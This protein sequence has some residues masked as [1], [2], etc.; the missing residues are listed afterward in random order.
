[1]NNLL[2]LLEAKQEVDMLIENHINNLTVNEFNIL[3]ENLAKFGMTG[4]KL[5]GTYAKS[6]N[7]NVSKKVLQTGTKATRFVI[8]AIDDAIDKRHTL[9]KGK[10]AADIAKFK[11]DIKAEVIDSIKTGKKNIKD[12]PKNMKARP[13]TTAGVGVTLGVY[14]KLKHDQ[15]KKKKEA[16]ILKNKSIFDKAKD[17]ANRYIG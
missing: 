2:E 14:G 17:K 12:L 7:R 10:D 6:A 9:L 5:A 8:N 3:N 11:G 16:E 4:L 15:L 13:Y 1:M